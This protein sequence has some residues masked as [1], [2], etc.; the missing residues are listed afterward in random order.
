MKKI[1]V[2]EDEPSVLENIIE[3][4]SSRD[5]EVEGA[6]NGRI[7]VEKAEKFMPDLVVCDIMM[8]EMD[9]Y[10]VLN[11]LQNNDLTSTIPFIFLTAKSEISDLRFGMELGADDYI[12]KPFVPE[13]LFRAVA[14]RL[15]K[16]EKT[17]ASSEKKMEELRM[18]IAS[19]LPHELRTPLNGIFASS[20]ILMDYYDSMDDEEIK[21]LHENIFNSAQRLHNL[22]AKYLFYTELEL[23]CSDK[24]FLKNNIHKFD[25]DY[26][27]E[28]IKQIAKNS[29]EK[30]DRA[31][32]LKLQTLSTPLALM[33]DHFVKIVEELVDNAFKFSKKGSIVEITM[34]ENDDT[35]EIIF[36]DYGRG[37]SSEFISKIGAYLQFDRKIYEQQGSGLGL[38][39][40]KR[41]CSL[42]NG[43]LTIDSIVNNSTKISIK[44]PKLTKA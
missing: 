1:L 17:L 25:T 7:G 24:Y 9:G 6:E 18:S 43:D 35:S 30:Y 15:E 10:D 12:S 21:Q 22:I 28:I 39:I 20:Q 41:L 3:L 8:P 37:I 16:H 27:A 26:P 40:V 29:A 42:Y 44:L 32:D 36:K 2:V 5:Y 23:L 4:L 33:Q 13:E 14:K 38:I 31:N 19:T 34:I 11:H